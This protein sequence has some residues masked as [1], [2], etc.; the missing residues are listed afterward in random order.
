MS[1]S[2][3]SSEP[4]LLYRPRSPLSL[5]I[6][7]ILALIPHPND[8]EP[9]SPASIIQRRAYAHTFAQ[10]ANTIVESECDLELSS[11]DPGRALSSGRH[12]VPRE[13][14]HPRTPED[15]ETLLTLL[16]LSIYEYSQRGNLLKMRYRAGQALSLALDK[17]LHSYMDD[18][19]FCEA[20]RRAWWMTVCR[21]SEHSR[22]CSLTGPVLLCHPRL[23]C[24]HNGAYPVRLALVDQ[25]LTP[26]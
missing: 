15:L 8:A 3:P 10:L 2:G 13:R 24:E 14:L 26:S 12:S 6:S 7:A 17:S 4:I 22:D 16:I 21:P 9:S 18:D 11:S 5:A 1:C 25:H 19:E 20:R 23:D